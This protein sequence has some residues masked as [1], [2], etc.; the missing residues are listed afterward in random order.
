M[1]N[2]GFPDRHIYYHWDYVMNKWSRDRLGLPWCRAV[3]KGHVKYSPNMC[4]NTL[5]WLGRAIGLHLHQHLTARDAD[6]IV[7]AIR[8]VARGL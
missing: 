5:H 3:Y 1:F 4:P 6:D 2:K 7:R 8:K